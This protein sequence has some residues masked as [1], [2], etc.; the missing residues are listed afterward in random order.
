[1][2]Y[3]FFV[4]LC[5][6]ILISCNQKV[7]KEKVP[8]QKSITATNYPTAQITKVE[9]DSMNSFQ[10]YLPLA[11]QS[12][13]KLPVIIFFDAHARGSLPVEMYKE[14]AEEFQFILIGLNNSK[15]GLSPIM[16]NKIYDALYS[17]ITKQ[18]DFDQN[19]ITLAGFS[20]GGRVAGALAFQN[21]NINAVISCSAGI[22][23]KNSM[24]TTPFHY[25]GIIGNEDFNYIELSNEFEQLNNK[26][27]IVYDGNHNWPNI[28]TMREAYLML[29]IFQN[30]NDNIAQNKSKVF[31]EEKLKETSNLYDHY[32]ILQRM[33]EVFAN[34]N[35]DVTKRLNQLSQNNEFQEYFTYTNN[36]KRVELDKRQKYAMAFQSENLKWWENELKEIEKHISISEFREDKL[37]YL[38][39]GNYLG[40]LGYFFTDRSLKMGKLDN[41][42]TFLQKYELVDPDNAD[43]FYYKAIYYAQKQDVIKVVESL[44]KSIEF[45]KGSASDFKQDPHFSMIQNTVEFKE[46][47]NNSL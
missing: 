18:I 27:L 23:G 3:T 6:L 43:M 10:L 44:K 37:M 8:E 2:K 19:K 21:Q 42:W 11:Y 35:S 32:L 20:G 24:Q 17:H 15:N 13:K 31:Y 12:N 9:I 22:L 41:M 47:I 36:L 38:R 29:R 1:M 30:E 14:L 4:S 40:M 25:V 34:E 7:E 45:G 33:D 5:L 39:L 16:Y 26:K 46:F 28:Q